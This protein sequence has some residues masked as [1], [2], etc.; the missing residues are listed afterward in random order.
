MYTELLTK[1]PLALTNKIIKQTKDFSSGAF[2]VFYTPE[3]WIQTGVYNLD[4]QINGEEKK[5][6]KKPKSPSI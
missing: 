1:T 3:N 2:Q 4:C 5:K 6:K